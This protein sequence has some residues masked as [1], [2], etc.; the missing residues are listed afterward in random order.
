MNLNT[1]FKVGQKV[2]YFDWES[3]KLREGEIIDVER[4]ATENGRDCEKKSVNKILL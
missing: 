4:V 2:F 3:E 1:K